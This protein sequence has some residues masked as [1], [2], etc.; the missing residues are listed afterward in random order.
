MRKHSTVMHKSP[1]SADREIYISWICCEESLLKTLCFALIDS[2]LQNGIIFYVGNFTNNIENRVLQYQS[3]VY[4][5]T[6][7]R[8][9]FG[10]S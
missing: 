1:K 2:I 6:N 4:N 3:F 5:N 10:I 7:I 9:K 8:G